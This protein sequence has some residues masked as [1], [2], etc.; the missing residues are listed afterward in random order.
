MSRAEPHRAE[1]GAFIVVWALLLVALLAMVAIVI[2]LAAIRQDRRGDRLAADAAATAG[3]LTLPNSGSPLDACN[4]A[5]TYA[6]QN[7][8]F[9][10]AASGFSSPCSS[11]F[12]ATCTTGASASK[13]LPGSGYI[14][15]IKSPVPD[16]DPVFMQAQTA[17][18]SVNQTVNTNVDGTDPC[19]RIGVRI[20]L[21]R[22]PLFGGVIGAGTKTTDVHSVALV[23]SSN[24]PGG[25]RPALVT[26]NPT[27]LC[28][29]DGGNGTIH[30]FAI[31]SQPGL[32]YADSDASGAAC[33][34]TNAATTIFNIGNSG[35]ILA[36]STADGSRHGELG[37]VSSVPAAK[38]W[39]SAGTYVGD[40]VVRLSPVTRRPVDL[41]YHCGNLPVAVRPAS[42]TTGVG[43]TDAIDDLT[44]RYKAGSPAGFTTFPG[45]GQNCNAPPPSFAAGNWYINCA[46]FSV[47]SAVTF[48]GGTIVF[49]GDIAISSGGDLTIGTALADS[50][51]VVRGTQGI[52][53]SSNTWQV[54]WARTFLLMTN[55]SCAAGT[56]GNCGVFNVSNGTLGWTPPLSPPLRG[57][58]YWSESTRA[59]T[60]QGNPTYLWQGIY[61]A[62]NSQF[63]LQGNV[64]V[65]AQNVQLWVDAVDVPNNSAELRLR[66]DPN[67]SL[68]VQRTS[69]ALIR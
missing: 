60:F 52:T 53:T 26:L 11:G 23:R 48:G 18:G 51:V 68:T 36:D 17:N 43:G 6:V 13:A 50:T 22:T 29:V 63:H 9:N 25:P 28:T 45:A 21:S 38:R 27:R 39:S 69:T 57:L 56:L 31:G 33:P 7:L 1:A 3:A 19:L 4:T 24:E 42:C 20:T 32:I 67:F 65:D 40:K 47:G 35:S 16:D 30:A 10:S 62:P 49:N 58:I 37:V 5:W 34:T 54:H 12:S 66:P 41:A 59:H 61:F 55:S 44:Q 46:S 8:G 64:L 15:T 2:D 14:V